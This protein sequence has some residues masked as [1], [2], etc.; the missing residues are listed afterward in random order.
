[1]D[2][3]SKFK[4]IIKL[5]K[6]KGLNAIKFNVSLILLIVILPSIYYII[7]LNPSKLYTSYP[8]SFISLS[9]FLCF[10]CLIVIVSY[11][12]ENIYINES[13]NNI[14][15]WITM[16]K[17]FGLMFFVF[18]FFYS[19]FTFFKYIIYKSSSQSII[20]TF[21]TI[22][23]TLAFLYETFFK[24]KGSESIFSNIPIINL[25]YDIIFYIPCLF[26]DIIDFIRESYKSIPSNSYVLGYMLLIIFSIFY[27][28]PL[29]IDF[30]RSENSLKLI[31]QPKSLDKNIITLN[32]EELKEKIIESR[33]LYERYLLQQNE[34]LEDNINSFNINN[35]TPS[36][37][38]Y[39]NYNIFYNTPNETMKIKEIPE[40]IN[41]DISCKND[42]VV[43]KNKLT[44]E[45]KQVVDFHNMKI[46][47]KKDNDFFSKLFGNNY[48]NTL[49]YK[50]KDKNEKTN[51]DNYCSNISKSFTFA[52]C[53]NY[54]DVSANVI[55]EHQNTDLS[56]NSYYMCKMDSSYHIVNGFN[57]MNDVSNN[58]FCDLPLV[59]EGFNTNSHE[60]DNLINNE[61]V[62]ASF[63]FDERQ[64]LK[65]TL[66]DI[67]NNNLSM[68]VKQIKNSDDL[69]SFL[70]DYLTTNETYYGFLDKIR[71]YNNEKNQF[72]YQEGSNLVN[73]INRTYNI[74]DYNY[75]YGISFW[76][77]FDS[78]ILKDNSNSHKGLIF[79]Y[80]DTPKVF[81]DYKD[82]SLKVS[83]SSCNNT[84]ECDEEIVY[85][86]SNILYQR[87]N[88][89]VINYNYGTLDLF[90]N[91]NLV[92]STNNISPY[93][94]DNTLKFGDNKHPLYNCGIC[95]AVYQEKPLNL[96]EISKIY[97]H[98]NNPCN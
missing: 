27:L 45:E 41:K 75:H 96:F 60:L 11:F 89:V 59:Q 28:L 4:E 64:L 13:T 42:I 69:R 77:Y 86:T 73:L 98:K 33:P 61:D 32:H 71:E 81:Y 38:K 47:C 19:S 87:W 2:I 51:V 36:Y 88:H 18:I 30:S 16:L 56:S 40:C 14:K 26:I 79:S 50:D 57:D 52:T 62:M 39:E 24:K 23:V 1:M 9:L 22:I 58:L 76:I 93:I 67:D 92:S 80:S 91:N 3:F 34:K 49:F 48:V 65:R 85:K 7:L 5:F 82:N 97:S 84:N 25:V 53:K 90:I 70:M 44:G 94:K 55:L 29:I 37:N 46:T 15:S 63:S 83:I 43:C 54:N 21:L 35:D 68:I 17:L 72:I 8:V 78:F 12:D 66:E 20:L 31:K 10:T 95:N 6:E 74:H